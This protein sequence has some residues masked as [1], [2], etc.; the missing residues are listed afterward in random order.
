MSVA[1]YSDQI[2]PENNRIDR[3]LL[4]ML[5]R[6]G[7][8]RRFGY[9][10]SGPDATR[11]FF[12]DRQAYYRQHGIDLDLFF[13]LDEVH[14][15]RGL[16]DLLRC[17]AIH[18]SGGHTRGFLGRIRQSGLFDVLREW[19][20]GGGVLVGTSAGAILTTPTIAVDALFSGGRPEIMPDGAALDLVPFEFFPHLNA[21]PDYLSS[22]IRYSRF[23]AHPI[24][25][26]RDGDGVVVDR[27]DIDFIGEPL[28]ISEG[29]ARPASD[30]ALG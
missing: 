17:D 18:L 9:V 22:L 21:N 11:S 25:A 30:V 19:A 5:T 4:D 3:R 7:R 8:G 24:V 29:V 26:C 6:Q 10:P 16:G 14:D 12:H 23:T 1:L 28:W 13:D 2:V 27:G 20:L 15:A